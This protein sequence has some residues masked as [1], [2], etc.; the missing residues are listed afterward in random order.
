MRLLIADDSEL[1][2][3]RL[4]ASLEAIKGVEVVDRAGTVEE[5]SE[6]VR[7]LRPDVVILDMQM[8]GGTGLDVLATMKRDQVSCV[9]IVLTNFAYPQYRKK[10]LASGANFFLDKSTEFDKVGDV[11]RSMLPTFP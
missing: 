5:A 10:C 9:V 2:V 11:L 6:A 1:I 7:T 3:D 4:I 8:P